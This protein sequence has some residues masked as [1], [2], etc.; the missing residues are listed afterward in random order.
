MGCVTR[1]LDGRTVQAEGRGGPALT[2]RSIIKCPLL[3]RRDLKAVGRLRSRF[4]RLA[5]GAG[6]VAGTALLT[7][8]SASAF[9]STPSP[10]TA[11]PVVGYTY[12]NDNTAA[13]NT[14]AGFDRHADGSLTPIPGSP[15]LAGGADWAPAWPPK[16]R[17]R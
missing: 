6:L 3:L 4:T 13:S 11:S 1:G 8:G 14:I 16:V 7:V 2:D 12:I 9:A 10:S 15:F 17:S 5:L